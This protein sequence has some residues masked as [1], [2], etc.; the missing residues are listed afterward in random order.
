MNGRLRVGVNLPWTH[1]YCGYDFGR[2]PSGWRTAHPSPRRFDELVPTLRALAAAGV[3]VVRFFVLADG[4]TY[5]S[6]EQRAS[7][8]AAG[9]SIAP[10]TS[11]PA[12]AEDFVFDVRSLLDRVSEAGLSAIP[13]IVSFEA[14]FPERAASSGVRRRGLAPLVFGHDR[15]TR[16]ATIDAF[17]DATVEPLLAIAGPKGERPHPALYAVELVNEPDWCVRKREVDGAAMSDFVRE[18]V[19]RIVARSALA[20]VGFLDG[21]PRWLDDDVRAEL[22]GLGYAGRYRP[23][24]HHYPAARER[25]LPLASLDPLGPRLFVGEM[26]VE[27][28]PKTRWPDADLGDAEDDPARYLLARLTLTER[29]GYELALLWS[30]FAKDAQSGWNPAIEAQLR[31]FT[32]GERAAL[33]RDS[34]R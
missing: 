34:L 5:P 22:E 14:F 30:I 2:P 3:E 32:R 1:A 23:Q 6:Q 21:H 18:G 27:R 11:L 33:T 15:P 25:D 28:G 8:L 29:R 17:L 19:R 12:L 20:T 10:G 13:S 9:R 4:L 24:R 16:A 26:A 31:A 7:M